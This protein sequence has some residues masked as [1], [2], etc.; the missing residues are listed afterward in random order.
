MEQSV[1]SIA[2]MEIFATKVVDIV[3][4]DVEKDQLI[5]VPV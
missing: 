5:D 1:A 3:L 4:T 2:L